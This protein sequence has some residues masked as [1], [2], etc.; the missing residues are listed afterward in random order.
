MIVEIVN[1]PVTQPTLY[2]E[3]I[4]AYNKKGAVPPALIDNYNT[5]LRNYTTFHNLSVI[6]LIF[7]SDPRYTFFTYKNRL[8]HGIYYLIDFTLPMPKLFSQLGLPCSKE[9]IIESELIDALKQLVKSY[10]LVPKTAIKTVVYLSEHPDMYI[11]FNNIIQNGILIDKNLYFPTANAGYQFIYPQELLKILK[12][13]KDNNAPFI[14]NYTDMSKILDPKFFTIL[15]TNISK[16]YRTKAALNPYYLPTLSF[17][18]CNASAYNVLYYNQKTKTFHITNWEFYPHKGDNIL[19]KEKAIV[20]PILSFK[21]NVYLRRIGGKVSRSPALAEYLFTLANG[22]ITLLNNIAKLFACMAS[23]EVHNNASFVIHYDVNHIT[24]E[25]LK[26]CLSHPFDKTD[27][28]TSFYTDFVS[29]N[30]IS[31]EKNIPNLIFCQ[32][33]GSHAL[34][35]TDCKQISNTTTT[36][37]NFIKKLISGENISYTDN[38]IGKVHLINTLPLIFFTKSETELDSLL[39]TFSPNEINLSHLNANILDEYF[40]LS[41]LDREW[42][43]I[44]FTLYGFSLLATEDIANTDNTP[45]SNDLLTDFINSC[46][47][48]TGSEKDFEFND[49][50]YTAYT[51]FLN[52]KYHTT[53]KGQKSFIAK[54]NNYPNIIARKQH[55]DDNNHVRKCTVGIKLNPRSAEIPTSPV[56]DEAL[57]MESLFDLLKKIDDLVPDDLYSD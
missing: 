50:L 49:V 4:S 7:N 11:Y 39:S 54:L 15:K 42:L 6:P 14:P 48:V 17:P 41:N 16:K 26:V 38:H 28:Y 23:P 31:A 22:K 5:C 55:R 44:N 34:A 20:A 30:D 32:Y 9:G 56:N 1:K 25:T 46:C 10:S 27:I 3:K 51:D 40:S 29:L 2:T 13:I 43:N 21:Q 24:V 53:D 47:I 33:N 45:T 12:D 52:A 57:S 35:I 18:S 19:Y 8:Y 36:K 37:S